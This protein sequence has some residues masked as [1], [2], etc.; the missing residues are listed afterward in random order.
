MHDS[1]VQYSAQY[2]TVQ[3][4]LCHAGGG[5]G[6]T[7]ITHIALTPRHAMVAVLAE[8]LPPGIVSYS[9]R[10][11]GLQL[12]EGSGGGGGATLSFQVRGC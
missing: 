10:F 4:R 11:A 7:S 1:T 3:Y 9:K 2:S 6:F 12:E 5:A 8:S